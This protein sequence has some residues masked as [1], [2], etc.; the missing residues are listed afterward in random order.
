MSGI[1]P[2]LSTLQATRFYVPALGAISLLGAWLVVRVARRAP[3][4]SVA[5][6]ATVVAISGLVSGPSLTC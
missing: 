5:A 1:R 4:V 3:L 2:V 6:A